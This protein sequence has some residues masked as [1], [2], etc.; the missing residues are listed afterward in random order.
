MRLTMAASMGKHDGVVVWLVKAGADTRA[1]LCDVDST[2]VDVSSHVSAS[3][4]QTAYLEAKTH[5]TAGSHASW[6]TGRRTRLTA[7]GGAR[8]KGKGKAK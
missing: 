1:K 5:C 4:N 8:S 6:R 3:A 2:V 7:S